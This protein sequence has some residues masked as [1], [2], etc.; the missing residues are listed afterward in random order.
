MKKKLILGASYLGVFLLSLILTCFIETRGIQS[1]NEQEIS[2][3]L[4]ELFIDCEG[5]LINEMQA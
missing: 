2:S 4:P 1:G 3:N 5:T